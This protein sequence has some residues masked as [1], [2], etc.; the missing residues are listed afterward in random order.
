MKQ[1]HIINIILIIS[2]LLIFKNAK[3]SPIEMSIIYSYKNIIIQSNFIIKHK[4]TILNNQNKIILNLE[5]TILIKE[6]IKFEKKTN[7]K[8]YYVRFIKKNKLNKKNTKI[9]IYI[10]NNLKHKIVNT[11]NKKKT[12]TNI[13]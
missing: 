12:N 2:S 10:K 13:I 9:I 1:K 7:K 8:N 3:S 4:K 11:K 5:N 6:M